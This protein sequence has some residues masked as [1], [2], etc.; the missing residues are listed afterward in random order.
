MLATVVTAVTASAAHVYEAQV[1]SF[2][3]AGTRVSRASIVCMW[4]CA[5][6]MVRRMVL[7][8]LC[9]GIIAIELKQLPLARQL[10]GSYTAANKVTGEGGAG[11]FLVSVE[12]QGHMAMPALLDITKQL[13]IT[14]GSCCKWCTMQACPLCNSMPF[15]TYNTLSC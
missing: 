6:E 13:V 8:C 14:S 4:V 15:A 7:L 10:L 5:T 1:L 11:E 9:R 12:R 3:V 2:G